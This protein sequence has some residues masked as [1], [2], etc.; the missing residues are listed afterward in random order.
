M[1]VL[2]TMWND[3]YRKWYQDLNS[4]QLMGARLALFINQIL[5]VCC[6]LVLFHHEHQTLVIVTYC[7]AVIPSLLF[8]I[9]ENIVLFIQPD[10]IREDLHKRYWTVFRVS[11][12]LISTV[13]LCVWIGVHLVWLTVVA[14]FTIAIVLIF[15]LSS[16][17]DQYKS[18]CCCGQQ[19]YGQL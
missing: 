9:L 16:S 13:L 5:W 7:N 14:W 1:S 17:Y 18:C 19:G 12:A 15:E 2:K 11:L 8:I 10:E 3:N 6:S 4:S